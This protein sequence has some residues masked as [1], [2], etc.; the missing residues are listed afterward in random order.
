[1]VMEKK[2]H[3]F[4]SS[5]G[6]EE[7]MHDNRVQ[8]HLQKACTGWHPD[9]CSAFGNSTYVEEAKKKFRQFEKLILVLSDENKIFMYD[10]GIHDSDDDTYLG[11]AD[12]LSEMATMMNQNKPNDNMKS[13]FEEIKDLFK[14]MFQSDIESFGLSSE[15]KSFT[16]INK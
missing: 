1:M 9:R 2:K 4:L 14:E 5:F 8:E 11:M 13:S 16:S 6:V 10:V 3:R 7:G 15:T 12:F